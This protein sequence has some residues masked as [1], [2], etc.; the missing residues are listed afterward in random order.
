MQPINMIIHIA[1][2]YISFEFK[3]QPC[4][5]GQT[6][7]QGQKYFD[8]IQQCTW[9]SKF[10][11]TSLEGLLGLLLTESLTT[12]TLSGYPAVNFLPGLGF[13][14]FL[15]SCLL[16]LW[17]EICVPNDKFG[18]S[19]DNCSVKLPAKFCLLN[20][21]WFRHGIS[22]DAMYFFSLV[23]GIVIGD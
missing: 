4:Q 14:A 11:G 9:E 16:T 5:K 23:L 1:S 19:W 12:P 15:L 18:F 2:S 8:F 10:W 7:W 22:S 17:P 21:E 13:S 20:F 6:R 3:K